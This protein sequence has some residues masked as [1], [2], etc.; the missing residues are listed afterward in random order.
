MA[1]DEHYVR[2]LF[3]GL[4]SGSGANFFEH[5]YDKVDWIVDPTP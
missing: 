1:V 5:V 4:E 3:R 2:K